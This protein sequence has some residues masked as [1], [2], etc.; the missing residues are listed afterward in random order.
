[1][2]PTRRARAIG[3]AQ[4]R[5]EDGIHS[6]APCCAA[7]FDVVVAS[8]QSFA[9]RHGQD[10]LDGSAPQFGRVRHLESEDIAVERERPVLVG[11]RDGHGLD[12]QPH[13]SLGMS[14]DGPTWIPQTSPV[15]V[16]TAKTIHRPDPSVVP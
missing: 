6:F 5:D 7:Q 14:L 12:A 4:G 9:S 13:S 2:T 16:S 3:L 8:Q 10:R 1:M 15:P 11:D